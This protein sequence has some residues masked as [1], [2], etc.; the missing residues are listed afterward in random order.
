MFVVAALRKTFAVTSDVASTIW[1]VPLRSTCA[2]S[3][4]ADRLAATIAVRFAERPVEEIFISERFSKNARRLGPNE[5]KMMTASEGQTMALQ[6]LA[7]LSIS[8]DQSSTVMPAPKL[9]S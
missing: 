7:T 8:L 1:L 3:L 9:M 6:S 2:F 4:A 5:R